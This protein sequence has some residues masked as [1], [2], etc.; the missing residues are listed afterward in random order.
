MLGGTFR[1]RAETRK[2]ENLIIRK[3]NES[4]I[5][6]LTEMLYEAIF[7][8]NGEEKLPKEIL[9]EPKIN[10][11][12]KDF[13]RKD[14]LCLVA[15]LESEIVGAIWSRKFSAENNGYGF[16]DA[17]TPELSMAIKAKFRGKGIGTNLLS[18]ILGKLSFKKFNKVSLSVDKR[19]YA[20]KMYQNH[21]FIEVEIENYSV[22]M[23]KIINKA[24]A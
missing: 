17:E 3:I 21:G 4:E 7:V 1:N 23:L 20:Y 13:G 24:N 8:P 11:Y 15:E 6:F 10:N 19:N 9:N 12:I 22:K 16:I 2:M 5:P 14:D 18:S